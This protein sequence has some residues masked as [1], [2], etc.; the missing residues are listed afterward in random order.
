MRQRV[1]VWDV[2]IIFMD[3]LMWNKFPLGFISLQI[4]PWIFLFDRSPQLRP[5]QNLSSFYARVTHFIHLLICGFNLGMHSINVHLNIYFGIGACQVIFLLK[6]SYRCLPFGYL[7][8]GI[9]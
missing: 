8:S 7:L 6:F 2:V 3:S 5:P 4:M 9:C 1:V